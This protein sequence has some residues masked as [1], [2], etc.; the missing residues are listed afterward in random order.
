MGSDS[1]DALISKMSSWPCDHQ[2][3]ELL[4]L[5]NARTPRTLTRAFTLLHNLT[6]R[7]LVSDE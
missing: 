7:N 4:R 5:N 6:C 1:D 2:G 3:S